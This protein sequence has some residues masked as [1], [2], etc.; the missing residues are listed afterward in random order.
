MWMVDS[1]ASP[2]WMKT[3]VVVIG[4]SSLVDAEVEVV[5]VSWAEMAGRRRKARRTNCGTFMIN[6]LEKCRRRILFGSVGDIVLI[7]KMLCSTPNM[8]RSDSIIHSPS[9]LS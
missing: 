3:S 2:H 9:D 4:S 7:V 8:K 5:V 6:V 1:V